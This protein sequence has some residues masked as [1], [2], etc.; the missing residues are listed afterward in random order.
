MQSQRGPKVNR[1]EYVANLQMQ[2]RTASPWAIGK[3][4]LAPAKGHTY[5]N[6]RTVL[7]FI[8]Q[9]IGF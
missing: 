7:S 4:A 8:L 5:R 1:S 9:S 3:H 2:Q 6:R